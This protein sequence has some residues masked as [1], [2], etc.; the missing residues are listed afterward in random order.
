MQQFSSYSPA[1]GSL[2]Q[3]L[4]CACAA[5]NTGVEGLE[6]ALKDLAEATK[7]CGGVVGDVVEIGKQVI[8]A[9]EDAAEDLNKVGEAGLNVLED[10]LALGGNFADCISSI[11]KFGEAILDT[12]GDIASGAACAATLG[13]A[14]G[15]DGPSFYSLSPGQQYLICKQYANFPGIIGAV[16][17][18]WCEQV[19]YGDLGCQGVSCKAGYQCGG[20]QHDT[21]LACPASFFSMVDMTDVPGI[22]LDSG[23]CGCGNGFSPIYTATP[24]GPV[25]TGCS[26]S[27]PKQV[28]VPGCKADDAVCVINGKI[29]GKGICGCP[30]NAIESTA[31]GALQCK[32]CYLGNKPNATQTL[33]VPLCPAGQVFEG[34]GCKACPP[35]TKA[36][37]LTGSLGS[38]EACPAGT[39]SSAG[40]IECLPLNCG[41]T[42]YQDPDDLHVCK[43]CPTGQTYVPGSKQIVPGPTPDKTMVVVVAGHCEK[44]QQPQQPPAQMLPPKTETPPAMVPMAPAIRPIEPARPAARANCSARGPLFINNPRDPGSCIRCARGTVP[45]AARNACVARQLAVPPQRLR[46]LPPQVER[47]GERRRVTPPVR[48]LERV[49]PPAGVR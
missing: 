13:F 28:S 16:V 8:G 18:Q 45:D 11:G 29:A 7:A 49:V 2:T 32:A 42:G 41:P 47:P 3:E 27:A 10:C 14:C 44:L 22:T 1:I 36:T 4:E 9:L 17:K 35:N 12:L 38:C 40:A 46:Q 48:R 23:L 6:K 15:D 30:A 33:C 25:L 37:Y 26:C 39:Q 43:Q 20:A 31:G 34:P 24:A 19:N 5:A 21:C